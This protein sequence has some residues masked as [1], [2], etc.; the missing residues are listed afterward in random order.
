MYGT[1]W[2]LTRDITEYGTCYNAPKF[3]TISKGTIC[4]LENSHF[5]PFNDGSDDG[6]TWYYLT[7]PGGYGTRMGW[8]RTYSFSGIE[9]FAE[10]VEDT[11]EDLTMNKQSQLQIGDKVL[12]INESNKSECTVIDIHSVIVEFDSGAKEVIIIEKL[13]KLPKHNNSSWLSLSKAEFGMKLQTNY[14]FP[15]LGDKIQQ[16]APT[17][18]V[19]FVSYDGNKYCKILLPT[20]DVVEIKA[21]Y[22]WPEA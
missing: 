22:L 18:T 16:S 11:Q 2:K 6:W 12:W 5:Q 13:T 1:K 3:N 7:W 10:E 14:P 8:T 20:G 9:S 4:T 21:G 19:I 15:E 17:R